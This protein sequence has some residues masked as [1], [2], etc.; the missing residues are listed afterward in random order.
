MKKTQYSLD[1]SH[2]GLTEW[3]SIT[4]NNKPDDNQF[5]WI[6]GKDVSN[7]LLMHIKKNSTSQLR[8]FE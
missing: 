7:R 5:K 1:I 6:I 2:I 3:D 4:V 8:L